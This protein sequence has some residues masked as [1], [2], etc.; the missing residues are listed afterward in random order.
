MKELEKNYLCKDPFFGGE[1]PSHV[2]FYLLANLK[3]KSGCLL[4]LEFLEK[5]VG[6]EF[7]HWWLRMGQLCHYNPE[8]ITTL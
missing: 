4:Y 2:D 7:W 8:R 3:T 5:G 1:K 6:G